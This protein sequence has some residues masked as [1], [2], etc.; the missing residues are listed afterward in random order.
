MA[1]EFDASD[2]K[3]VQDRKSKLGRQ[4]AA[5]QQVVSNLVSTEPG[6]SW[7]YR[8]L[9]SCHCFSLSFDPESDRISAFREGERNIGNRLLADLVKASPDTYVLMMKEK[10]DG[11]YDS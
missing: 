6:R 11:R 8:F 2:E 9:E 10:N 1:N 4:A 5:D 7:L 3:Q